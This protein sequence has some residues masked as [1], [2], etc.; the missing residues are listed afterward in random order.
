MIMKKSILT[1]LAGIC[2]LVVNAQTQPPNPG[3]ENWDSQTILF[4]TF[5]EPVDYNT[6]T[7][8]TAL[9][10]ISTVTQSNDAHSG[11]YSAR[12]ETLSGGGN[13]RA[14]GVLTTAE[15]ICLASSGGQEGGYPYTTEFPGQL[16]G[17]YKY[18]PA[19]E[20]S[21]YIQIMFLANNE[22]DTVCYTRY[23]LFAASDWTKFTVPLCEGASGS[24]AEVLS[25]FFSSSWGDGSAGEAEVGSVLFLDD[26]E[27]TNVNGIDDAA[28]ENTWSVYPNPVQG[29]LNVQVLRGEEANIEIIDVTGK[30][31]KKER[32]SEMKH[33]ID[34]NQLVTGIYL[35]QIRSLNNEVLRTGKLLV[36]P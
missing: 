8:C 5:Q 4:H 12:L 30:L 16:E 3:F 27:F 31:V 9:L 17:W 18:A 13:I 25:L 7:Q 36:N 26:I 1:I 24:S 2:T 11:S 20:D 14:N 28:S 15:L 34:V 23:D 35:Y 6:S 32:I 33:K 29:E 10:N 22:Q 21:A 19:N